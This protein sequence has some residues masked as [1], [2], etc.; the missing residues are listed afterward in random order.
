V[1]NMK[2]PN[3]FSQMFDH[4]SIQDRINFARHLSLVIK[5]GLPV[6]EGLKI[7]Q[8]QTESNVLKK[9]VG[10]LI[11]DINNGKFLADGLQKYEYLFGAFFVNI[12]RVG[13]TSG[14]LAKNLVYLAEELRRSKSLESKVR[15]AL[16]Y[17]IVILCA[18]IAVAGFL[19]FFVFPKLIPVF[20]S[21]NIQLPI[22]TRI[23]LAV[24]AFLK[25]DGIYALLGAIALIVALRMVVKRFNSIRYATDQMLFFVPV[26]SDL[27]VN[28]N[29]V[30]FTRVLGLLLKSG[31]KIV[32]ALDITAN[33]FDNLVYRQLLVTSEEEI[34]KGGQLGPYLASHKHFFPPLVCG[35]VRIGESTGNLED[36]LEYLAGYYDEDVDVKLHSLT[37]LIEPIMLLLMG[38]L[39]GFVALSIITPIY[40]ISQGIK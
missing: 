17:P 33:T 37:S 13:E 21:M 18:T 30:N 11:I 15:S 4:V 36:N 40:S 38:L 16:V 3:F 31:V 22:T 20:A 23:L 5:A 28:I 34:K 12:V 14:T 7:V 26:L 2:K 19:T 8:E 27:V 32:E 10:D 35:M 29:M 24:L 1:I 9:V 6:Y 25:S 39:V